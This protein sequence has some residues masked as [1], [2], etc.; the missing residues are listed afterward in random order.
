ML[1]KG[2]YMTLAIIS[3]NGY[4]YSLHLRYIY[5]NDFIYLHSSK[6]GHKI[7]NIKINEKYILV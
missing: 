7:E 3:E 2:E 6:S 4:P 1:D 5:H